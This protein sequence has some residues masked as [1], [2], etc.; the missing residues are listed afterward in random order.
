MPF[1]IALGNIRK[2]SADA[3]VIPYLKPPFINNA[4]DIPIIKQI[5]KPYKY[6]IQPSAYIS[7]FE[8]VYSVY[9]NSLL[10]AKN[11]NLTSIAFPKILA[12]FSEQAQERSLKMAISAISDFLDQ[13]DMNVTL[14]VSEVN[15]IYYG[16]KIQKTIS[17]YIEKFLSKHKESF[18]DDLFYTT[19]IDIEEV[20][21]SDEVQQAAFKPVYDNCSLN[22][23]KFEISDDTFS[24]AL[25]KLIDK[26]GLTDVQAYRKA[27][28]DRK[29]FS[30]I[31]SDKNY[32][33]KKQ[34]I[35][36]FAVA[37]E[38]DLQETNVLLNKA[39][40]SL[41]DSILFDVII[42]YFIENRTYDIYLI[43]EVLFAH[44]QSLLGC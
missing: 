26:K 34:T 16:N 10:C 1:S 36:A 21:Y 33:P 24:Q 5:F 41:S 38:L 39:G 11:N 15:E 7:N 13:N 17:Q 20:R 44:D 19:N 6:I 23:K 30:K 32:R 27:N 25:L 40:Y 9:A 12:G 14:V 3:I 35:I 2:I 37:L 22:D 42:K 18:D 31:R 4:D 29:L 28:V 8:E 43:N